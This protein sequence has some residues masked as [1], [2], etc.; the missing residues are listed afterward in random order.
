MIGYRD[1]VKSP[2]VDISWCPNVSIT[3]VE[4][5]MDGTGTLRSFGDVSHMV[6][7][8]MVRNA[9]DLNEL[10]SLSRPI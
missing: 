4:V 8:V 7:P 10:N 1:I 2:R 3:V 5:Q 9:D 6:E